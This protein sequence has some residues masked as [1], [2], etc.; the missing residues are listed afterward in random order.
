MLIEKYPHIGACIDS[1]QELVQILRY[2]RD[3]E[4][5]ARFG[6]FKNGKFIPGVDRLTMDRI[7]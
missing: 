3:Y 1:T 4:L 5:E 2:N 6:Q 7:I